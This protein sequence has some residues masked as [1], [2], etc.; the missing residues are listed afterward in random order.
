MRYLV[1]GILMFA[2]RAQAQRLDTLYVGSAH[3]SAGY[4]RNDSAEEQVVVPDSSAPGGQRVIGHST[5]RQRIVQDHG[6]PVLFRVAHFKSARAEVTDSIMVEGTGLV[7]IWETSH[8]T[9]KLMHLRWDG[10]HVTGD[11]TPTGKAKETIDQTMAVAPFN[12]SDV[13]LVVGSLSLTPGYR[14][15][16]ATYEYESGGL[17]LD[18]LAVTG[19][20]KNLWIVRVSRGDSASMTI[21]L[22]ADSKH[23][24]K[25]EIASGPHT[26]QARIIRQ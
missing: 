11:V 13:G 16:L 15:L 18:T 22:D 23:V 3:L 25:M 1:F 10:R 26:W 24:G 8:Q 5:T 17:R 20:E 4:M 6:K 19:H 7:P 9:S 12:S 21:W 2:A 14:A